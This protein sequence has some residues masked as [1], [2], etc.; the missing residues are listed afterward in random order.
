MLSFLRSKSRTSLET[1]RACGAALRA[2]GASISDRTDLLSQ[3]LAIPPFYVCSAQKGEADA[4][5]QPLCSP[6]HPVVAVVIPE[7]HC[8]PA[9]NGDLRDYSRDVPVPE[10]SG[11]TNAPGFWKEACFYVAEPRQLNFPFSAI[12]RPSAGRRATGAGRRCSA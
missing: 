8:S 11:T 12:G 3:P 9:L 10:G 2:A 4:T 6:D 1:S 7:L 5:R